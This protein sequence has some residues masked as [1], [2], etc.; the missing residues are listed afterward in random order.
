[1]DLPTS[2]LELISVSSLELVPTEILDMIVKLIDTAKT[3]RSFALTCS[4]FAE[5]CRNNQERKKR[6]FLYYFESQLEHL[7]TGSAYYPIEFRRLSYTHL[8]NGALHGEEIIE[9]IIRHVW[10]KTYSCF[11]DTAQKQGKETV[12]FPNG[13]INKKIEWRYNSKHGKEKLWNEY[14]Q[15]MQRTHWTEG[16]KHGQEDLY[17]PNGFIKSISFWEKGYKDGWEITYCHPML[18]ITRWKKGKILTHEHKDLSN[19][20]KSSK[21]TPEEEC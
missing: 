5:I 10:V 13:Q 6:E 14:G 11:W 2:P 12:W 1:M 19:Q 8:P 15:L 4:F 20:S 9:S 3:F 18:D 17:T 21:I 16:E 7:S